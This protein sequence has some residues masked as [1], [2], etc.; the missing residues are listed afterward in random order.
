MGRA[1]TVRAFVSLETCI[2]TEQRQKAAV[3][4]PESHVSSC[5][6][7]PRHDLLRSKHCAQ[8]N[9]EILA[10]RLTEYAAAGDLLRSAL[11]D[12]GR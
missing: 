1:K 10:T 4:L 7:A 2:S 9:L 8:K 12:S 6:L 11:I 3:V 5:P